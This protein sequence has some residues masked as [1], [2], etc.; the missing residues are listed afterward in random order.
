MDDHWIF[1]PERQYP[2]NRMFEQ[3]SMDPG[4]G[5]KDKTAI[6][7]DLTCDE[8]DAVWTAPGRRRW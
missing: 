2:F 3:K 8:G 7:C 1:F 5:P 4:L 6:C